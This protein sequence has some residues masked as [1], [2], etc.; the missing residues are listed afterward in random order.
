MTKIVGLDEAIKE[1]PFQVIYL[2]PPWSY[3]EQVQHGGK[4]A[5]YTSSA[6]A[7]YETIPIEDLCEAPIAK[8]ADRN[9]VIFVWSTGPILED[10][11][12]AINAWGFKYK[13]IA[14]VWEKERVN[15]GA[16]TM[17]SCE[18]V[19]VATRGSIPK[20]RGA[21][22][23]RQFLQSCRTR[24]SEKPEEIAKRIEAM[25][26]TQ[27]KIELFAR[28]TRSGWHCAGNEVSQAA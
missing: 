22:N 19:L 10:S 12:R 23:V 8:L 1:G 9:A 28:T 2:D 4:S 26:P 18:Y 5:G 15:P 17:S 14:F 25:F 11:L 20:P 3:R 16:Y 24:H 6:A 7:F 13:T 21:R 27:K